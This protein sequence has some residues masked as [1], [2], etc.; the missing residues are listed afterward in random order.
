MLTVVG[1]PLAVLKDRGC[2]ILSA[3]MLTAEPSLITMANSSPPEGLL[4]LSTKKSP[5]GLSAPQVGCRLYP[6]CTI[7]PQY[8]NVNAGT[9]EA[10]PIAGEDQYGGFATSLPRHYQRFE[11]GSAI[12]R[13]ENARFS[14]F[15][16]NSGKPWISDED[17][18]G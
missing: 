16:L 1:M 13:N 17:A 11:G 6:A 7:H 10:V 3:R 14:C 12:C 8:L 2:F 15:I 4:Y 9:V 5:T 18:N